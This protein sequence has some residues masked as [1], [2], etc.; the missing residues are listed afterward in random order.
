MKGIKKHK[1][2]GGTWEQEKSY[3]KAHEE[4][5]EKAGGFEQATSNGKEV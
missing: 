3:P 1:D 2:G 4:T 5:V